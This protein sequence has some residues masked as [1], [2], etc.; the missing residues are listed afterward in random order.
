[1]EHVVAPERLGPELRGPEDQVDPLVDTR[2]H[3][4]GLKCL[5]HHPHE[6]VCRAVRPW[7][8]LHVPH[9]RPV[10]PRAQVQA[11]GILQ[12]LGQAVELRY[13][14]LDVGGGLQAG[15]P[16]SRHGGEELKVCSGGGGVEVQ[17]LA[18]RV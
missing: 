18:C 11:V 17:G 9:P 4:L 12:K 1:M 3:C 10:L 2:R 16:T 7:G 14:L 8:Q 15:F 6:L 5:T 13:E